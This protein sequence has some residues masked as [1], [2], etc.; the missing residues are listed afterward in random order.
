MGTSTKSH[1]ACQKQRWKCRITP[2]RASWCPRWTLSL[3]TSCL[4]RSQLSRSEPRTRTRSKLQS[5]HRLRTRQPQETNT[6]VLSCASWTS[7]LKTLISR[8]RLNSQL[9]EYWPSTRSKLR[10]LISGMVPKKRKHKQVRTN[11][12]KNLITLW[13]LV[14]KLRL[15]N[16]PLLF[17]LLLERWTILAT[18]WSRTVWKCKKI[19]NKFSKRRS[20]QESQAH[21]SFSPTI[22]NSY[23][24]RWTITKWKFSHHPSQNITNTCALTQT[25]LLLESMVFSQLGW[26]D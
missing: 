8:W 1:L 24:K 4:S 3:F 26:K 17:L 2:S 18:R 21:S 22:D 11:C 13:P 10:I 12:K 14:K 25:P 19:V 9:N 6:K 15:Q 20:R 23:S 7:R 5:S 16:T